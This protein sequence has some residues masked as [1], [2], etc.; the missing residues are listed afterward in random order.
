MFF[1]AVSGVL[2]LIIIGMS[3]FKMPFFGNINYNNNPNNLESKIIIE[4]PRNV[5]VSQDKQLTKIENDLLPTIF[6]IYHFKKG[7]ETLANVYSQSE[8]LGRGVS[9]TADGWFLTTAEVIKD[10][11]S[12]YSLVGYQNKKY[13]TEY[14]VGDKATGL[15]FGKINGA[16]NLPVIN[17]G[18]SNDLTL[19]QTLVLVSSRNSLNVV[20]I[21]KIGYDNNSVSDLIL[22]SDKLTKRI[23]LNKKI[24]QADEGSI[25]V[26]F[27]GEVVGI[28][29]NGSAIPVDFFSKKIAQVLD[30]KQ[31]SRPSLGIDYLDLA[32]VDGLIEIAEKGAYVIKDPIKGTA[33]FGLIKKG[34]IIK[35]V[36]DDELNAFLGLA[37]TLNKYQ[38]GNKIDLLVSR[39]GKDLTIPVVLK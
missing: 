33:V 15:V 12:K 22:N 26:N 25:L 38:I 9:L 10:F 34:D 35:K 32:Q 14:L 18:S 11:K 31:T 19:G 36:N 17:F 37:E 27:K 4:Q 1:G 5:I 29:S 23:F 28:I 2:T 13:Q 8:I 7:N 3:N 30:K 6:N 21:S 16:V 20:T 39:Q 24:D